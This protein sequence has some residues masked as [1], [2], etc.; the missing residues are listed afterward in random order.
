MNFGRASILP[1]PIAAAGLLLTAPAWSAS[2]TT[3]AYYDVS[4]YGAV[5]DDATDSTKAINAALDAFRTY[6][7]H[8]GSA[9]LNFPP[10]TYR[11]TGSLNFTAIRAR[12]AIVN[13]AGAT[14]DP[15][16][17]GG[18]VIDALNS[19]YVVFNQLH[20]E[21]KGKWSPDIGFAV[22]R[23][24]PHVADV[25]SLNDVTVV[26]SFAKCGIYNRQSETD[27]W[28]HPVSWNSNSS[29]YTYCGDGINHFDVKS[30]F[31]ANSS[32]V[33]TP[34]SFNENTVVSGD[35]RQSGGHGAVWLSGAGRHSF[36]GSYI[37]VTG[38]HACGATF[39]FPQNSN[40]SVGFLNWDVH[41]EAIGSLS[42]QICFDGPNK[43]PVIDGL[44]VRDH[45]SEANI[46]LLHLVNPEASAQLPNF[47]LEVGGFYKNATVFDQPSRW[48]ASGQYHLPQKDNSWNLPAAAFQGVGYQGAQVKS[49]SHA[50]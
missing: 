27:L 13:M 17:N 19:R 2:K 3:G 44:T 10:G 12:G 35:F 24:D 41:E 47:D 21:G 20:I 39:Y 36:I 43:R 50:P 4:A 23:I 9:I 45:Y 7:Q 14:I 30:S 33:D 26:G 37:A 28:L 18:I 29:G 1:V 22:G 8:H 5:P 16:F 15:Q 25:L 46:S 42:Y 49:F 32:P 48:V 38:G 34:E 11:I 40:V 6:T 31:G